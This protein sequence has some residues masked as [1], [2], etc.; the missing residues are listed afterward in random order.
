MAHCEH[1]LSEITKADILIST[2]E[3]KEL[4]RQ[5]KELLKRLEIFKECYSHEI[6]KKSF[7][8]ESV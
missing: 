5:K 2:G 4:K 8:S 3:G 7:D 6:A 1:L